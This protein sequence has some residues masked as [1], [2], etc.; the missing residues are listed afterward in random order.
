MD[1]ERKLKAAS[2]E[3]NSKGVWKSNYNPPSA[4]L[5]QMLGLQQPPPYYRSF[6]VNFTNSFIV[7]TPIFGVLMWFIL[8][9]AEGQSVTYAVISSSIAGVAYGVTMALYF[10]IQRRRLNLKK[11]EDL[12][13]E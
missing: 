11:W 12:G 1:Y 13:G 5:L 8:W 6:W 4:K 3:L 2:E 10:F 7:Y 9:S